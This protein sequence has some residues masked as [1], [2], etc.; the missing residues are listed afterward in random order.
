MRRQDLLI[1][2]AVAAIVLSDIAFIIF[3]FWRS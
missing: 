3:L 1:I 2:V